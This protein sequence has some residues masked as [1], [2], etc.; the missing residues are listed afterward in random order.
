MLYQLSYRR[1]LYIC[2]KTHRKETHVYIHV[3]TDRLI[4]IL[5]NLYLT[6]QSWWIWSD[7]EITDLW[8]NCIHYN[9][10]G[11]WLCAASN[12]NCKSSGKLCCV[13][14]MIS[15]LL[16]LR[17]SL[18]ITLDYS[19]CL[20][21][22]SFAACLIFTF[23]RKKILEDSRDLSIGHFGYCFILAWS[24]VPLLLFSGVLY[25]HLRKRQ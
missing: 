12:E 3:C 24:C 17:S 14:F 8:S 21:F 5:L 23:H 20:C 19:V 22:T 15:S 16:G 1:L 18:F 4:F 7:A 2:A 10:T 11:N 25:V 13:I 6:R 9:V